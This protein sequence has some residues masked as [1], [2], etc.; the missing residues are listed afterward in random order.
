MRKIILLL[1]ALYATVGLSQELKATMVGNSQVE[2][3]IINNENYFFFMLYTQKLDFSIFQANRKKDVSYSIGHIIYRGNN[4]VSDCDMIIKFSSP[5]I[6]KFEIRG[7][8][9]F[10]AESLITEKYNIS[11]KIC[12]HE[13]FQK[14]DVYIQ[15]VL[16]QENIDEINVFKHNVKSFKSRLFNGAL[17]S[18]KILIK[19]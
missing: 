14:D 10:S 4:K 5:G 12:E 1:F 2:L 13:L 9:Y 8:G 18:N 3:Q 17:Y 11:F 16:S 19:R 7:S 15:F 6:Q